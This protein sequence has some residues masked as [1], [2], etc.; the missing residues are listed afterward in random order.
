MT[1]PVLWI[2]ATHDGYIK[3]K[4]K[5]VLALKEPDDIAS[6]TSI[7]RAFIHDTSLKVE[8]KPAFMK[9]APVNFDDPLLE[10]VPEAYLDAEEPSMEDITRNA[11]QLVRETAALMIRFP[12]LWK[13]NDAETK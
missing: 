6:V 3:I 1:Q 8:N 4:G 2:R 13:E 12:D 9:T 7:A 10:L 5:R 11:D